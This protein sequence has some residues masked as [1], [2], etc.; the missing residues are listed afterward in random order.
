MLAPS[1]ACKISNST[2]YTHGQHRRS[3][4]GMVINVIIRLASTSCANSETI[5]STLALHMRSAINQGEA[6]IGKALWNATINHCSREVY[7]I[8]S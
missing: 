8:S 5:L 2:S 1:L 3:M 6:P 4:I 7:A